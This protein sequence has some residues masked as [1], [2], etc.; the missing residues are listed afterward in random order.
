M[1]PNALVVAGGLLSLLGCATTASLSSRPK[2]SVDGLDSVD[3][4]CLER[5]MARIEK[6]AEFELSCSP[7]QIEVKVLEVAPL[8]QSSSEFYLC[9]QLVG[10]SG[11]GHRV[12]YVNMDGTWLMNT[13]SSKEKVPSPQDELP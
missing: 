9:P 8:R 6:R 4:E 12:V 3:R 10:V 2:V 5:S 13:E 11:C 1:R 7:D